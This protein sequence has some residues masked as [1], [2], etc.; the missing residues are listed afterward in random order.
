MTPAHLTVVGANGF[1][2]SRLVQHL[3]TAGYRC[4]AIARGDNWH[5]RPL[6]HVVFCAGVTG[7]FRTR[8]LDAIDAHVCLLADLVRTG[9]FESLVYLSSTRVYKRH[10][11]APAHE[12]DQLR[13]DPQDP[14]DLYEIS[15]LAGETIALGSSRRAHVV[16]LSNV[17][18]DAFDQPGFLFAVLH[19]AVSTGRIELQ[20]SGASC[21][22]FVAIGDVVPLVTRIALG[23]TQRVYNIAS[24][25]NLTSGEVA[26]AI[27]RL[28][29]AQV[30][31]P[32]GAPTVSFPRIDVDRIRREF[33]VTP[34]SLLDD[35][36][37]LVDAAATHWSRRAHC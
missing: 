21:R 15:K 13:V 16:R 10:D 12:D 23:G 24:G 4:D 30:I 37:R 7:D 29:G 36:P 6:G 26:G 31:M 20:T 28:S 2:G 5:G 25:A 35:L 3:R 8:P 34:R 19:A 11:T 27:A 14:D 32:A 22:D 18:G 17:Y 33:G 1:I 9:S